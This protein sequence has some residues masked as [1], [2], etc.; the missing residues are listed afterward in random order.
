MLEEVV[1]PSD[2]LRDQ[3]ESLIECFEKEESAAKTRAEEI[4]SL[5]KVKTLDRLLESSVSHPWRRLVENGE[6]HFKAQLANLCFLANK[7]SNMF[8]SID[9][10]LCTL[11][12]N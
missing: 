3:I 6:D 4:E 2:S 10:L 9:L 8:F 7:R 12:R 1:L 11:L 5:L